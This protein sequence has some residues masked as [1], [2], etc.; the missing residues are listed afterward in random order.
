LANLAL[1]FRDPPALAQYRRFG[2]LPVA[3]ERQ[4]RPLGAPVGAPPLQQLGTQLKLPGQLRRR[5]AGIDLA[6]T[7]IFNSRL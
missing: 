4:F 1:Q 3:W 2:P 6:I 5:P 7:E